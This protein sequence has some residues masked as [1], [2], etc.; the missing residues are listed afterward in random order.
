MALLI[1]EIIPNYGVAQANTRSPPNVSSIPGA[2][3]FTSPCKVFGIEGQTVS[4]KANIA[5]VVNLF[6][7]QIGLFFDPNVTQCLNVEEGGF[8]SNNGVDGVFSFLGTIDNING[9]VVPYGWTLT[10]PA[11][12]K[13]GSGIL[14]NFTFTMKTTGYSNVHIYGFDALQNDGI[15]GIAI[16]TI[17]VYTPIREWSEC[18]INIVGNAQGS[19]VIVSGG[20]SDHNVKKTPFP[21]YHMLTFN[22]TGF[23]INGNSFAFC[24]VSIPKC[25]MYGSDTDEPGMGPWL[26]SLNDEN[27]TFVKY[28]NA[29]HT[30]LCFE[31]SYNASDPVTTVRIETA[32]DL[33]HP[34]PDAKLL[35]STDKWW[36]AHGENVR[37][38]AKFTI[39]SNGVSGGTVLF[40]VTFPNMSIH[41][42]VLNFTEPN[43]NTTFTFPITPDMPFGNY[44]IH[45]LAGKLGLPGA[46]CV[47][48]FWVWRAPLMAPY[49]WE[50]ANYR[51][52]EFD[53]NNSL[54]GHGWWNMSYTRYVEPN[55]MNF[56]LQ[57]LI[58][59][60]GGNLSQNGW[61]CVNTTNR[62]ISEGTMWVGLFYLYWIQTNVSVG[63][64]I[65][66][67]NTTGT[68]VGSRVLLL[69]MTDGTIGFVD[70]WN[71]QY[72]ET[73]GP[74]TMSHMVYFDKKT[75]H[76]VYEEIFLSGFNAT[77]Y[78]ELADTNIPIAYSFGDIN[79]D[80]TVNNTDAILMQNTWLTIIG[81][82]KYDPNID[83]NKDGIISIKDATIIGINWQKQHQAIP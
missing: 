45:M 10:N 36:Y 9:I 19:N 4:V 33:E 70:C 72:T 78:F 35:V 14:A 16:K 58:F 23:P 52:R 34:Y 44:T 40:K 48:F 66:I 69:R 62:L 75:G 32:I 73:Q 7:F 15:T 61:A 68:V 11:E 5:S 56:S 51:F 2:T 31:F 37:I 17:D 54:I 29:T 47:K 74:I 26:V 46:C 60:G 28:E 21:D 57:Y 55:L 50:R 82:I 64:Q 20:Y 80:G 71:L 25:L 22:V 27:R 65:S 18:S 30:S 38:N 53:Q 59:Y 42:N 13:N 1:V 83:F 12:A 77:A 67:S 24:N 8:L 49:P 76:E 39:D 6:S 79:R 81:D 3:I 63:S 41:L 43:G